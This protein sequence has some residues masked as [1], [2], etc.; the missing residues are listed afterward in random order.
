M[1]LISQQARGNFTFAGA[2]RFI[3]WAKER[4][5][6]THC[7]NL[8]WHSQLPTWVSQ[9]GFN[10]ATLIGIMKAHIQGLAGRYKGQCTRWD[11]VNEGQHFLSAVYHM[12]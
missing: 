5:Y 1:P 4:N 12:S 10:N 8:V 11:V 9:G 2:D 3:H 6:Q 7:H